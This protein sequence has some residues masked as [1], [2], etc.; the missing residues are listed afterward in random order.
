MASVLLFRIVSFGKFADTLVAMIEHIFSMDYPKAWLLYRKIIPQ[1]IEFIIGII[2]ILFML[3]LFAGLLKSYIKYFDEVVS[4]IDHITKEGVKKV[5][6]SPELEFIEQKL[7]CV[8]QTLALR[9]KEAQQAEQQKNELV[10][11]LAHD[12]RTPLTSVIGYLNL[13]EEKP[14]MS[15]EMKE[16]YLHI[17][18]EKATRLESLVEEFFEIM[19][20]NFQALPLYVKPI[21][22]QCMIVQLA[23]EL[24]PLRQKYSKHIINKVAKGTVVYG[25]ADKLARAFNNILKN[26]IT[27][28]VE[29]SVIS[30]EAEETPEK[31]V[32]RFKNQGEIPTEKINAIFDKFYRLD[33]ARNSYTGGA[34][35]G[36]AIA[37]DII[38]LHTGEIWADS[39]EGQVIFTIEL[40]KP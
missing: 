25:D 28:G 37:K 14:S 7:N 19:R 15:S 2:I 16:M 9:E 30:I 8:I 23:D 34:G 32:I 3:I 40:P 39:K 27:Y 33:N 18:I 22:L 29:Q 21:D 10:V 17:A 36:L 38:T 11:Y 13:L 26:A 5:T 4:G 12:I 1:N 24:Y 31:T 6:L 20:Y 35:L